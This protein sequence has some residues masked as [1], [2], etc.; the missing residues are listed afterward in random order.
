M[1]LMVLTRS[2]FFGLELTVTCF[3]HWR[4]T[5]HSLQSNARL[6]TSHRLTTAEVCPIYDK[7]SFMVLFGPQP[8]YLISSAI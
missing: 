6:V 5:G 2:L 8:L 4:E 1:F 7:K 3:D